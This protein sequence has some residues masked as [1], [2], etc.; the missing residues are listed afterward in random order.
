MSRLALRN[1]NPAT[2]R[3]PV[4]IAHNATPNSATI[5]SASS[6]GTPSV[7]VDTPTERAPGSKVQTVSGQ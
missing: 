6:V 1:D 2:S 4:V 5:T 7:R 3:R